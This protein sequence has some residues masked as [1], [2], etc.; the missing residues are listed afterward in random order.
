[1]AHWVAERYLSSVDDGRFRADLDRIED[2]ARRLHIRFVQCLYLP[3]DELCLYLFE[4]DSAE[5]VA[6]LSRE[7]SL[8]VDRIR[9]AEVTG[10]TALR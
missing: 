4:S 7:A 3:G 5:S 1:M 2:A 8:D 6:A 9:L 10:A